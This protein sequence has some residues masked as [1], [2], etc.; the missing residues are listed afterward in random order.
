VVKKQLSNCG[1]QY[2]EAFE[3]V[4]S[5]QAHIPSRFVPLKSASMFFGGSTASQPLHRRK[6]KV[7]KYS[8]HLIKKKKATLF[9]DG[10][11]SCGNLCIGLR[12]APKTVLTGKMCPQCG[13]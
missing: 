1:C 11:S 2:W 3:K 7:R 4:T 6:A 8:W 5:W 9:C 13:K 12:L 10:H